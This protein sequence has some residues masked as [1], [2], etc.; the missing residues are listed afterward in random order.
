MNS[1]SVTVTQVGSITFTFNPD[2]TTGTMSA[3]VDGNL[4][5]KAITRF[6]YAQPPSVCN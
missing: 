5:T 1:A 6:S 2:E 3:S 4:V